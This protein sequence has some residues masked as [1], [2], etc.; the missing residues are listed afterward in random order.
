MKPKLSLLAGRHPP[1]DRQRLIRDG[2][3]EMMNGS[4]TQDDGI[5]IIMDGYG[6]INDGHG[7]IEMVMA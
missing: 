6:I 1:K 4:L 2:G 7:I 3:L 5:I